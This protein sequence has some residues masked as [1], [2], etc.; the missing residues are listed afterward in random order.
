MLPQ[1]ILKSGSSELLFPAFWAPNYHAST[2]GDYSACMAIPC[3]INLKKIF[4]CN[5][6]EGCICARKRSVAFLIFHPLVS[7]L[8]LRTHLTILGK[9]KNILSP[10]QTIATSQRKISQHPW[11]SICIGLFAARPT[12][13]AAETVMRSISRNLQLR[14]KSNE[15]KNKMLIKCWNGHSDI[16]VSFNSSERDFH[17]RKCSFQNLKDITAAVQLETNGTSF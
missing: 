7:F 3:E 5:L 1:K 14:L 9:K 17:S 13:Q 11:P 15:S 6:R 10:G 2:S 16:I 4:S 12:S 8:F